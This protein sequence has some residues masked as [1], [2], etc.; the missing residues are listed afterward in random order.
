MLTEQ[1]ILD[2]LKEVKDPELNKSLVELNM[3]RDIQ[4]DQDNNVGLTVVLTISGCPLKATIEKDVVNKLKEIG[5]NQVK[6]TFGSMTDQERAALAQRLRQEAGAGPGAQSGQGQP[7]LSPLLAPDSK[8]QFIAVTSGKG[9][10]GKSTVTVN[11]AKALA[12]MGKKVGVIDADI[13]GFSVPDM[14]G[15]DQ[16]PT[17][18][19]DMILPVE[20]HGVK[21]MSM[22]FFVEDNSPVIWR[23]PMLGKMLR[24]FFSQVHW[25]ELE[26]MILDLPPGTGDVALDV[27]TLI[28]QSKEI[29]VTTPHATAAFVAAR[30]GAMA[31]KTKHEILGVVENMA[32]YQ[33]PD[34][35][36]DYIFGRGGGQKLAEVLKTELLAQ[37]PLGQP[38]Q[39]ADVDNPSPSIYPED[40]VIGQIYARMAEKIVQRLEVQAK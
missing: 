19:D 33:L 35:S 16:R 39:Q 5:A 10:V 14:M 13:Y 20:K 15:I 24:N 26:Y 38:D 29:I 32:Y 31:I 11:L 28:P 21:V 9:G 34:G 2:A 8:T 6:V 17:V 27:H 30:A 40:S 12:R 23:G 1:R 3:I 25:G 4:V 36:K 18:I 22:G 7:P 37:V